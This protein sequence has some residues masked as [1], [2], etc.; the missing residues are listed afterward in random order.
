MVDALTEQLPNFS[1]KIIVEL[2]S[3]WGNIA[4]T[5][6]KKYKDCRVIGYEISILPYLFSKAL[7]LKDN[8]TFILGDFFHYSLSKADVIILHQSSSVV[9]DLKDK[10][11]K[12][13][14]SQAVV[15]S[16][17]HPIIGWVPKKK[18][19]VKNTKNTYI[20]EYIFV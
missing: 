17:A 7:C 14:K 8:I 16:I 18:I 12:E 15:Y 10:L 4:F 3:C 9:S 5:L 11:N 20:Y 19:K 6:S 2:G 1:S 13:L